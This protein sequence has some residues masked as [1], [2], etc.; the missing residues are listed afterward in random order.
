MCVQLFEYMGNRSVGYNQILTVF[1][2]FFIKLIF[3]EEF[4]V[5]FLVYHLLGNT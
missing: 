3:H 5:F 1:F 4:S 2:F